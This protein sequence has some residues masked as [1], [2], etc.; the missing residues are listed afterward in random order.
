MPAKQKKK[1]RGLYQNPPDSGIWWVQW[2][3]GAGKR[4]R[5]KAGT[6][7]AALKLR[8]KRITD[9]LE[10]RKIPETL[11]HT[12]DVKFSELCKDA[13]ANAEHE[14]GES[15][16]GNLQ[17][18]INTLTSDFGD[19][20]ASSITS[21][22]LLAWLRTQAKK[23]KWA[24]GTYNHYLIQLCVIF[25]VG[26]ENGKMKENP[27]RAIKRKTLTNDRPRYLH[28]DEEVRLEAVL[29][30]RWPQHWEAYCFARN[31]GLR[32]AAQFGLKW[33]QI[34]LERRTL[35]LP[36]RRNS[37]YKKNRVLPLNSVAYG[38]LVDRKKRNPGAKLVFSE[39]HDGP[40]YLSIPANWFP[41]IV[42]AAQI[43]DFTWHSLRHDF[44]SQLV[45][46]NVPL[47]TVQK[48]MC[49]ASIKQ[50]AIYADLAPEHL[51]ASTEVLVVGEKPTATRT[52]TGV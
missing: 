30:T 52:A 10:S 41:E 19:R 47:P 14:N 23:R 9:R 18:V 17:G 16:V 24:D 20:I 31:T 1:I 11:K 2:F 32:A 50:T 49:H 27:A 3:D 22:E 38:I 13:I 6:K 48:L 7:S 46:K 4:H 5:E 29:N 51:A 35:T 15:A 26:Q 45:M 28:K 12:S 43:E 40:E 21:Q 33:M 36:P 8:A 44:A 37:K 34:D 42:E 25:R 39:Y